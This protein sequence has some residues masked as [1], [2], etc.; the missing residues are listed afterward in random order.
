MLSLYRESKAPVAIDLKETMSDLL[1][2]MDRRFQDLGVRVVSELPEHLVVEGFPA[3]LRQVFTNLIVNAAEAAGTNGEVRI[4]V[5][6]KPKGLS[7]ERLPPGARPQSGALIEIFDSGPG[8]A[9]EVREQLFEPFFT[10]KG[11]HGTGLGLWVCKGIIRKHGGVLDLANRPNGEHRG[12]VA[13]VFL[14]TR[15]TIEAGAA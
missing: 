4:R 8:I 15:P 10:T 7:P 3:E 5:T 13:T 1:L 2:L 12:A 11:E 9:P 6:P 14:S